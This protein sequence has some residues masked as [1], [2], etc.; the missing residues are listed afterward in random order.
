MSNP[1]L[2]VVT[3]WD[4][5]VTEHDTLFASLE[6]FVAPDVLAALEAELDAGLASGS[7]THRE[8]M[9]REWSLMTATLAEVVAFVRQTARVRK[10]FAAFVDRFN[11][12]ILSSSF[13]ETISPVLGREGIAAPRL[14]ANHAE[15]RP[16][17][18]RI[19]WTSDSACT[20]CGEPC[21]RGSLPDAPFVYIGD[22][23]SDRCASL[24]AQRIFARGGLARY[25]HQRGV[26]FEAFT[27]FTSVVTALSG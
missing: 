12:L 4:G 3:D 23:Y 25:L 1:Q 26:D 27:D 15:P 17:G 7:I 20:I 13:Y 14:R 21:K 19:T 24:A 10:G 5:T 6:R 18:W 2:E 8:V 16:S 9:E 11:P 22:G